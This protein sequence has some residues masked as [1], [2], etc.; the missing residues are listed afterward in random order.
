MGRGATD[1][2]LVTLAVQAIGVASGLATG[3]SV[4]R[5]ADLPSNRRPAFFMLPRAGSVWFL[6]FERLP[7][8]EMLAPSLTRQG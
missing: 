4:G 5:I 8:P 1:G 3:V 7:A 2:W 6:W